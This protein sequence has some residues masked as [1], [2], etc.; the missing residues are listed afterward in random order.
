[1]SL[2]EWVQKDTRKDS[3]K[4]CSLHNLPNNLWYRTCPN[5]KLQGHK[6]TWVGNQRMLFSDAR[7]NITLATNSALAAEQSRSKTAAQCQH[8]KRDIS[9]LAST[10]CSWPHPCEKSLASQEGYGME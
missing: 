10:A 4:F 7:L 6:V 1:M 2:T 8:C 3:D 5:H 9:T